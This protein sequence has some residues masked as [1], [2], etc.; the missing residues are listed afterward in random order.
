M[1]WLTKQPALEE[2]QIFC[3]SATC[4]FLMAGGN[5]FYFVVY[6]LVHALIVS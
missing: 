4:S 3:L 1:A 6:G 5:T 2:D